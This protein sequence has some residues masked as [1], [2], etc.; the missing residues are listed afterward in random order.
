MSTPT[1]VYANWSGVTY[2]PAGGSAVPI[3]N[4]DS[5]DNDPGGQLSAY[6]GS[7]NRFPIVI[8]NLMN[9]PT[10]SVKSSNIG[11]LAALIP[12]TVGVLVAILNDALNGAGVASG[13]LQFTWSNCVVRNN[14]FSGAHASYASGTASFECFS[15][16]GVTS[17]EA[18]VVK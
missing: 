15:T 9:K 4:V 6:S 11:V 1:T 13:A 10:V 7:A 2:T 14:P 3:T 12:G 8:A 16:D 5:I 18:I 17:P